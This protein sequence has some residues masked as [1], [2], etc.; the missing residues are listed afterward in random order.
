MFSL[1]KENLYSADFLLATLTPN[2]SETT[3]SNSLPSKTFSQAN[4]SS[5][6]QPSPI[7]T[8]RNN[9]RNLNVILPNYKWF[10]STSLS[11]STGARSVSRA[12]FHDSLLPTS[13]TPDH[14]SRLNSLSLIEP[15]AFPPMEVDI[16]PEIL[17]PPAKKARARHIF[18]RCL[19]LPTEGEVHP[20]V[21]APASDSDD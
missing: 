14:H 10:T 17:P 13:E 12:N 21:F 2:S 15:V 3:S 7:P 4:T 20:E 19:K 1:N 5:T 18:Q 16:E 11:F 6:R 8:L 9:T